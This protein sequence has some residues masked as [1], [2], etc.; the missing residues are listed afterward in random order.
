MP[1]RRRARGK[2]NGRQQH[3]RL[4]RKYGLMGRAKKSPR[5]F[6]I[7]KT[8]LPF[9]AV[10]TQGSVGGIS[11]TG[12][13]MLNYPGWY[14][15]TQA[16]TPVLMTAPPSQYTRLFATFDEYHVDRLSVKWMPYCTT[17]DLS[18]N[19]SIAPTGTGKF[20]P[21][22]HYGIDLDSS[23]ICG[24][25]PKA[26]SLL[27]HRAVNMLNTSR[28][29][30]IVC[31]M[32][33]YNLI[34]KMLYQNTGS[35]DPNNQP[36]QSANITYQT[37]KRGSIKFFVSNWHENNIMLETTATWYV[38]F[39]GFRT[40]NDPAA[41]PGNDQNPTEFPIPTTTAPPLDLDDI[42]F[43]ERIRKLFA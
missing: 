29:S 10:I 30:G 13:F 35:K 38:T 36:N 3:R 32:G 20:Y 37:A 8:K 25:V 12:Q 43:K 31:T 19:G 42:V 33:Q 17:S 1:R 34:D 22:M 6:Y 15:P 5:T 41:D 2:G 9:S 26:E 24:S 40:D 4:A 28:K 18:F 23:E 21:I 14:M 27:K 39:R 16:S 7:F 11:V